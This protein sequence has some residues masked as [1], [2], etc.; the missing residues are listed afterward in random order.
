MESKKYRLIEVCH[1]FDDTTWQI[2]KRF[3]FWWYVVGWFEKEEWARMRF[4]LLTGKTS[5]TRKQIAP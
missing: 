1:P 2:E 5:I 4:D 3:L